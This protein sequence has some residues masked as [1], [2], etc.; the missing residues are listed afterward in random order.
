M[1]LQLPERHSVQS[2]AAQDPD[3]LTLPSTDFLSVQ[4][5]LM[6]QTVTICHTIIII[7]II[8]MI[9]CAVSRHNSSRSGV[10]ASCSL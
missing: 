6:R 5:M 4:C 8:I 7:I 2:Q 3:T 9:G 1:F 10:I